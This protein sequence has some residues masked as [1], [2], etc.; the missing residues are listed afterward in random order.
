MFLLTNMLWQHYAGW[1]ELGERKVA[2]LCSLRINQSEFMA[3]WNLPTIVMS[4]VADANVFC[5][6]W[7]YNGIKDEDNID[8][9]AREA[10]LAFAIIGTVTWLNHAVL[11]GS[12]T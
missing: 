8:Q 11:H 6:W 12:P 2:N 1:Q 4:I 10:S 3:P 5:D 7:F 9:A